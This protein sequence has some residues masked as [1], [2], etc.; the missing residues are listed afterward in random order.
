[1]WTLR[2]QSNGSG[3]YHILYDKAKK[4]NF[5]NIMSKQPELRK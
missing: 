3:T 4:L 1:M 5:V 2:R